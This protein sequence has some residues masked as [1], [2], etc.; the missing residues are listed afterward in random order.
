VSA[1]AATATTST[2][3]IDPEYFQKA[4]LHDA[5][6]VE[7]GPGRFT[8]A[9][10]LGIDVD[11]SAF[12]PSIEDLYGE[13]ELPF[14]RAGDVDTFIELANC[15]RV[16]PDICMTYPTL[17]LVAPGDIVFTKGGAI[18]RVGLVTAEAA[19]SRDLIVL[20]TSKLQE[21]DRL[22]LFVYFG[23][24]FFKRMLL[25]S[26][27]Q[28]TQPH[29]TITLVRELPLFVA[30]SKFKAKIAEATKAAFQ[31]RE[32]A[33]KL[34]AT[35][36]TILLEALGLVD[37]VPP[38]PLSYTRPVGDA[39]AAERLDAE[40]FTPRTLELIARLSADRLCVGD[41]AASRRERFA[42]EQCDTFNYIEIG[43]VKA[44]G[45]AV[46]S[47]MACA[48]A[49]SRAT[50][51]VRRGDVITSTVRPI[52]RLSALIGPDQDGFV[53]SS[54]FA[55]LFAQKVRPEVLLTYLRLPVICE[56]MNLHTSAS[57][58]PAISEREILALPFRKVGDD[59]STAICDAVARAREAQTRAQSI[60]DD[61][62]CAVEI[63]IEESEEA[64]MR[65][66]D[67]EEAGA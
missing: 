52:R 17:A 67:L 12:Y 42:K 57:M 13:G 37:W 55:V 62:K 53:C 61:A 6:V 41:V 27:S 47:L 3:R 39:L 38:E 49:P 15:L 10:N 46:S 19:V 25:R 4:H 58:Y 9:I 29:L 64:A 11:A 40:Y 2:Q 59:A 16:P 32:G 22:F 34:Q 7:R 66:L 36:E 33:V 30:S 31:A 48:D 60:L 65:F 8:K 1:I 35:A 26:S 51:Y 50:W 43:D 45:S 18:D 21:N 56:L 20:T 63:A 23:T 44:D 14:L 54:G 5:D 28:T 24:S